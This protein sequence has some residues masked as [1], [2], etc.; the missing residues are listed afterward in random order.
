MRS[1]IHVSLV[2]NTLSVTFAEK[3]TMGNSCVIVHFHWQTLCMSLPV[4]ST[5][6]SCLTLMIVVCD[7]LPPSELH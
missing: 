5:T 1:D 6:S 3:F 4:V 2:M 7:N